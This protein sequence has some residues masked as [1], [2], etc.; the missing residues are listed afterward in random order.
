MGG[1]TAIVFR[2]WLFPSHSR[3]YVRGNYAVDKLVQTPYE[4]SDFKKESYL[5]LLGIEHHQD[6]NYAS[7]HAC[8][9]D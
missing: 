5:P 3:A 4:P 6:T 2:S 8:Q 9:A 1:H 7:W